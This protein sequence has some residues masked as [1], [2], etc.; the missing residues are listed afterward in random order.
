MRLHMRAVLTLGLLVLTA[1]LLPAQASLVV[2]ARHAEK[3]AP[4]GDPGL[5]PT[6]EVRAQDLARALAHVRLAA[7]ITTQYRRTQL[8]AAP[9]ALAYRLTPTV[10]PASG[11]LRS[12]ATAVAAAI[13]ALPAGSAALVVGHSNTLGPI[14]AALGGP[15]VPELCDG[16]YS[17]LLI[18]ERPAGGGGPQLLRTRFGAGDL[19]AASECGGGP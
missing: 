10:I 17:T 14:I 16:E 8:T 18:L 3:S 4:T 9:A 12:D 5:T 19:P 7:V 2:L 1:E 13:N 15:S 6:G 11:D